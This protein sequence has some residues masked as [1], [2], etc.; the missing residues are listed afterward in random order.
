[1]EDPG[2]ECA[3]LTR[4]VDYASAEPPVEGLHT[5]VNELFVEGQSSVELGELGSEVLFTSVEV[6]GDRYQF[7]CAY[8]QNTEACTGRVEVPV[9]VSIVS[10]EGTMAFEQDMTWSSPGFGFDVAAEDVVLRATARTR[11]S[12]TEWFSLPLHEVWPNIDT[13][14][15]LYDSDTELELAL[16]VQDGSFGGDLAIIYKIF[17]VETTTTSEYARS[18]LSWAL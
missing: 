4:T 6:T 5:A 12:E 11:A 10:S 8:N 17:D 16:S 2:L 14:D 18:V 3:R 7:I 1:M 13:P 15:G 9:V